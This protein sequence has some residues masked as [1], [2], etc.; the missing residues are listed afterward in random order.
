M[1][2]KLFVILLAIAL[3]MLSYSIIDDDFLEIIALLIG[4]LLFLVGLD[5]FL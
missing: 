1:R 5:T 4:I 2:K 3:F